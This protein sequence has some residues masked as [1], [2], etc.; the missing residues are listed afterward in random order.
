MKNIRKLHIAYLLILFAA[1]TLFFAQFLEKKR[2]DIHSS[3]AVDVSVIIYNPTVSPGVTLVQDRGWNDPSTLSNQIRSTFAQ[4][5]GGYVNYSIAET[6]VIDGFPIKEDGFTYTVQSY[7]DCMANSSNCHMPD[8]ANY[9]TIMNNNDV[10]SKVNSGQIDEVW[11]WGGPYFGY[12]ESRLVGPNS[13]FWYNSSPVYLPAC[14][15]LVPV[16]GFNYERGLDAAL[17]SFGHRM[18][19]TMTQVYGGWSQNNISTRWAKF[20]LVDFQSPDYNYSGCGSIHYPSNADSEYDYNDTSNIPSTCNSY[21]NFPNSGEPGQAIPL[22]C[23]SWGC[24]ELGFLGWWFSHIPRRSGVGSDGVLM[25][26]WV[27]F[28]DPDH[29]YVDYPPGDDGNPPPP[30]PPEPT[31]STNPEPEPDPDNEQ[32]EEGNEGNSDGDGN[33]NNTDSGG[34]SGT[35]NEIIDEGNEDSTDSSDNE[36]NESVTEKTKDLITGILRDG[37]NESSEEDKKILTVVRHGALL[38]VIILA[39]YTATAL[40]IIWY[41]RK[42]YPKFS[43]IHR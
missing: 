25:N 14:G 28:L 21:V 24:S 13:G 2:M 43:S 16:M 38:S 33:S 30:P 15:Q 27:Y 32:G 23:S 37:D 5:S 34:D 9:T 7:M 31:P 22:S 20:G 26:W 12:Y 29:V 41:L 42:R 10:C 36:V 8:I 6:I 18:E 35:D 1:A 40:S 17:H 39:T 4:R 3:G 11:V 19:S